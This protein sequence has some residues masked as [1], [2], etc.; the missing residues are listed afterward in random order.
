MS[1]NNIPQLTLE[2]QAAAAQAVPELTLVEVA[3]GEDEDSPDKTAQEAAWV[4]GKIRKLMDSGCTVTGAAGPRPLQYGDIA[5]L[6]RSGN[7][8]GPAYCRALA[9]QGIPVAAVQGG[10]Y[11]ASVEISTLVSMLAVLDNP[12]QDIPLIAVLRSPAFG[13]SADALSAIRG[14]DRQSDFYTALKAAAETDKACRAFLEKLERL[15]DLAADLPMAELVWLL[16]T[17]LDLLALCSAMRDGAQRRARLM[18]FIELAERYEGSGY[19]GLHRFV[20]WLR[21]LSEKGQEPALGGAES[22]AVQIMSIHKSKGLEFP[23]VFLCDTARRFN[24]QDSRDTVLVHPEL[25]LGPKLTDTQRHVEYPTLARNAIKLRLEREMLS[26]EMR[27]LYVAMTRAKEKLYLTCAGQRM[28]FGRTSANRPSRF[29]EEIPPEH[30]ERSGRNFLDRGD[31]WG[32]MPSRTSGYGGY[33]KPE[34]SPYDQRPEP[35]APQRRDYGGFSRA[36]GASAAPKGGADLSA[37]HKGDMVRHKA[38]GQGMILSIQKMGGDALVEI[39][40]DNVGTKR[41]MLKSAAAHM[42]KV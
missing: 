32:G 40:F 5:I 25:G 23:V 1:E 38:F 4:A 34:R 42:T 6:L 11:F 33:A 18:A 36:M 14:A 24:R 3:D 8:V 37:F 41:L 19:R 20:L 12:H 21:R 15:R 26:E 10:D 13:F 31:S 7:A 30:L 17:E 28:L 27:L 35:R 16:L 2:P 39:A 29:L 9:E 22:S